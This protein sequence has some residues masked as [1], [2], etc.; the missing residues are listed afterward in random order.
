MGHALSSEG[1]QI[2]PRRSAPTLTSPCNPLDR[3]SKSSA[4]RLLVTVKKSVRK[5]PTTTAVVVKQHSGQR[6]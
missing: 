1:G 4:A 3:V 6:Y 5:V 2:A